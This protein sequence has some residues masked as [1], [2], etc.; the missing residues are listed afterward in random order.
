V[1]TL[2]KPAQNVCYSFSHR[3]LGRFNSCSGKRTRGL[4]RFLFSRLPAYSRI[5]NILNCQPRCAA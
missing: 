5:S 2:C 3:L 1:S 4:R